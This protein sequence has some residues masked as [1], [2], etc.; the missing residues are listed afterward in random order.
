M[1]T[2]TGTD[3]ETGTSTAT[4]TGTETDF[5][6]I[7]YRTAGAWGGGKGS[8]LTA[9]E[10]DGNFCTLLNRIV[11]LETNPAEPVSITSI[12]SV[13]GGIII[14]MSDGTTRGPFD[15]PVAAFNWRG[16]WEPSTDYEAL[17][18]LYF[19][20]NGLVLVM[21]DHTSA[22][23]F[24]IYD[25]DTNGRLYRLLFINTTLYDLAFYA[26]GTLNEGLSAGSPILQMVAARNFF[27]P[28]TTT[29]EPT[30]GYAYVRIPEENTD[31]LVLD[32]THNGAEVGRITFDAG[33]T[34]GAIE[35]D[36]NVWL[37]PGDVLAI[38]VN[39]GTETVTAT[40]T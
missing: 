19:E 31:G 30:V 22:S 1:A 12:D 16:E 21:A 23:E 34:A 6:S 32:I 11:D 28:E 38:G 26:P 36:A 24:N 33:E 13:G 14:S 40:G 10:V 18:L 29:S 3:T 7:V 39:L 9:A 35:I 27:I 25:A 17:D 15:W 2:E 4:E 20:D 8:P 5:G 37:V